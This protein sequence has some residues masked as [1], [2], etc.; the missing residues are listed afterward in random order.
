MTDSVRNKKFGD[1]CLLKDLVTTLT[2]EVYTCRAQV[3]SPWQ[4]VITVFFRNHIIDL[5]EMNLLGV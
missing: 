4:A 5:T 1:G 2:L 3:V